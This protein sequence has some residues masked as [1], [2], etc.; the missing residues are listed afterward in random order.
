[1]KASAVIAAAGSS[2]RM[3]GSIP[4][5]YLMCEDLPVLIRSVKAFC[6]IEDICEICISI[7]AG[8]APYVEELLRR[9]GCLDE[10]PVKLS[11]GGSTRQQSVRAAL[12]KLDPGS[13]FVLVHD[14]ARPFVSA[15][16]INRVLGALKEGKSAV[17]P[18]VTPKST[19]RTAER[20]LDRSSLFEVQTPQGFDLK[21][22]RQA[23]EK[24]AEDGFTGTDEAGLT[25]RLGIPTAIVQGEYA[26]I[27][28][29]TPEDM[30]MTVRC[31]TG[32]DVHR[33][34]PGRRL[35]LGCVEIPYEKGLSGHSDAD[36]IAHALA[37]AMLGAAALGD[38]G[39]IFPD[40]SPETEGMSGSRILSE[41]AALLRSRGFT[42]ISAD[43]TLVAQR[44]KVAPYVPAMRQA[45]A[46]ALGLDEG[47][48][49]I[50]AT[51]EEGLGFTGS[52]EGMAAQ[53]IVTVR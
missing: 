8:D 53:A 28:I 13:D 9:F 25:E 21:L 1:M 32:Y 39:K 19:I 16:V 7:P 33:L 10:K 5:Q 37:D 43:A 15:D 17:I 12:E 14:G 31:G 26:N 50:K 23:F 49:S 29:T 20:T 27:K 34:V 18:A 48:V 42:L 47:R 22:L 46:A 38:I 11:A 3:G 45:V 41:T 4:K 2:Q 52:G 35:M 40:S 30:P 51:T 44:P 24:A 36:V 6:H